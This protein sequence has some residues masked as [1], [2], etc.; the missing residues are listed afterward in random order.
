MVKK[1]C[2]PV[3]N[4]PMHCSLDN[5]SEGLW[6]TK[7]V[8]GLQKTELSDK[9]CCIRSQCTVKMLWQEYHVTTMHITAAYHQIIKVREDIAKTNSI[10]NYGLYNYQNDTI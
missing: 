3:F 9:K 2:N 6:V 7:D 4:N 10:T 1:R 5:G 8:L